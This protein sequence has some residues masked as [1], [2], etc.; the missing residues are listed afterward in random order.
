ML[1]PELAVDGNWHRG[2]PPAGIIGL[3]MEDEEDE[4]DEQP[5]FNFENELARIQ[6]GSDG[7]PHCD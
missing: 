5:D 7:G 6:L 1:Q 3:D 4:E 2:E